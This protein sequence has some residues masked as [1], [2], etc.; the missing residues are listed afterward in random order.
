M[1]TLA[2]DLTERIDQSIHKLPPI[3][4]V[5]LYENNITMD[6]T[7]NDSSTQHKKFIYGDNEL[8]N[9][10]SELLFSL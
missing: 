10:I 9:R 5:T 2:R 3:R 4:D 6:Y 8:T 1:P 7:Y